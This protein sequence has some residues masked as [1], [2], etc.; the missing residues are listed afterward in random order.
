MP[1]RGFKSH[2]LF[3]FDR[4]R[5]VGNRQQPFHN[6]LSKLGRSHNNDVLA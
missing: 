6:D 2:A 4:F 5:L 1:E 3:V